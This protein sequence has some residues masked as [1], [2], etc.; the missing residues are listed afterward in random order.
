MNPT[1]SPIRRSSRSSRGVTSRFNDYT[2]GAEF[3]DP[4]LYTPRDQY[5]VGAQIMGSMLTQQPV[6]HAVQSLSGTS[7][8]Y[9]QQSHSTLVPC[10]QRHDDVPALNTLCTPCTM[11]S[12]VLP[13]F[14]TYPEAKPRHDVHPQQG[15][16]QQTG[17]QQAPVPSLM[18]PAYSHVPWSSQVTKSA[19][20]SLSVPCAQ[21]DVDASALYTLCA[22]STLTTL[23]TQYTK[24]SA[25]L[26]PTPTY[27]YT[28][29]PCNTYPSPTSQYDQH[30][31]YAT[32]HMIQAP[33]SDENKVF[34]SDGYS[35]KEFNLEKIFS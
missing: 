22:P 25:V 17:P 15:Y 35:W 24:P 11:P 6:P 26:P 19:T 7:R 8:Q 13:T 27:P 16:Q 29:M 2:P 28:Y 20:S 30:Q 9:A 5:H 14:P 1:S 10:A 21:H 33:S 12:A 4:S 34:V 18:Y 3:D 23:C 31:Q 32:Q